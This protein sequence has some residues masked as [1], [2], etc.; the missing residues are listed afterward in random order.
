MSRPPA[1]AEDRLRTFWERVDRS[2]GDGAC[3]PWTGGLDRRGY[4]N[5]RIAH[6]VSRKGHR[7]AYEALVGPIPS[8][9]ELD[10]LCRNPSCVNPAH[11][12]PVTHRENVIRGRSI[13]A[14]RAAQVACVHGHPFD[15]ANTS[16][17]RDNGGRRCRTCHLN[18]VRRYRAAARA[19]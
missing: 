3:W 6:D 14:I 11:L 15:E 10:H 8:G 17:R 4:C 19:S 18:H 9:L 5:F 12:E 1:S 13:S 16:F 2:A 7:I